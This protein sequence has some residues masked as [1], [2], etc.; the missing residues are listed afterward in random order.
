[1]IIMNALP[2]WTDQVIRVIWKIFKWN[3]GGKFIFLNE[4][5]F[6]Q[7]T[8]YIWGQFRKGIV[9]TLGQFV[10]CVVVMFCFALLVVVSIRCNVQFLKEKDRKW[11]GLSFASNKE[12]KEERCSCLKLYCQGRTQV[13]YLLVSHSPLFCLLPKTLNSLIH[14]A[15]ILQ[16]SEGQLGDFNNFL[17]IDGSIFLTVI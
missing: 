11:S 14:F 8:G 7:W 5:W 16:V 9:H 3:L 15:Q 2:N 4:R 13:I 10:P 17:F 6:S 1:M 12:L